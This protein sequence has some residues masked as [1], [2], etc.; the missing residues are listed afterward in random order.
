[1]TVSD[2]EVIA[3]RYRLDDRIGKGAMG[4]VWRARDLTLQRDVALKR[5]R[6]D[7]HVDPAARARFRREAVAMAG[8]SHPNVVSVYDAGTDERADGETAYLVMELLD[9]PSCAQLISSAR[10]L[11]LGEVERIGAGVARG[12]SAAHQAGV[13]HRDIKPGNVVLNRGVAKIV[14][15]GIARL[16]QE[17]TATL[18]APQSTIGTAAYMSPE[19]ALGKPVGPASDIYSLGA[20]LMALA[21]GSPPFGASNALA[22]MR[23][24]VDDEPPALADLRDDTPPA[25]AAL[26]ARMLAKEPIDRPTAIEVART[27]EGEG[28]HES[29][30]PPT[31]VLPIANDAPAGA[32]ASAV[33]G[34]TGVDLASPATPAS[35]TVPLGPPVST[36]YPETAHAVPARTRQ[37][38]RW[39]WWLLAAALLVA[40]VL[41]A[42]GL[43]GAGPAESPTT[44]AL[45]TPVTSPTERVVTPDTTAPLAPTTEP[46]PTTEPTQETQSAQDPEPTLDEAAAE[47]ATAIAAVSDSDA[48]EELDKL[49]GRLSGGLQENSAPDKVRDTQQEADTLL[50]DEDI[51]AGEHAAITSAIDEVLRLLAAG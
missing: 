7:G 13:V 21:T 34:A 45:S 19:Q 51:T 11:S 39:P 40:G 22:I 27:L 14:D 35:P 6:L 9:G 5:V 49:W 33:G 43:L 32:P 17:S 50:Q 41:L 10:S 38:S 25:L 16:E 8:V 31:A 2:G 20:L 23:A 28:D 46:V 24:H 37:S 48:R 1:M 15:F 3:G 36:A 42:N 12:L 26:I 29:T 4:E 44:P 18:T 30:P 47:V